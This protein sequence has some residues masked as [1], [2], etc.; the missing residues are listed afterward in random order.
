MKKSLFLL[1]L[2][3]IFSSL[4][5]PVGGLICNS[6]GE[7]G[8]QTTPFI[9]EM[10]EVF[11]LIEEGKAIDALNRLSLIKVQKHNKALYELLYAKA[12]IKLGRLT[13][14]MGHLQLSI[15]YGEGRIK[16]EALFERAR[17]YLSMKFYPEAATAFRLF[18]NLFPDSIFKEKAYH[19][20]AEAL[21][22]KGQY[23][24][25]LRYYEKT[26]STAGLYGKANTL[27]LMG[28]YEEAN[29][30]YVE[31]IL[32]DPGFIKTSTETALL[33]GENM[34]L[35]KKKAE[36]RR[37]L[38]A[39]KDIPYRYRAYLLL[40][41]MEM[42]DGHFNE[43]LKYLDLSLQSEEITIRQKAY[44]MSAEVLL[45]LGKEEEAKKRLLELRG[46]YPFGEAYERSLLLLSMIYKKE[47][48]FTEASRVLRSLIFRRRLSPDAV[49]LLKEILLE[50]SKKEFNTFL[51]LWKEHKKL[52][53]E[54]SNIPFLFEIADL[55]RQREANTE[56]SELS[57]LS[58]WLFKN[59]R[60]E[61][62]RKAS[63]L[64]AEAYLMSGEAEIGLRILQDIRPKDD[65]ELRLYAELFLMKGEHERA[66]K[67]LL[68]IKGFKKEDRRL[69]MKIA[70][71]R[72]DKPSIDLLERFI[73][74]YGADVS[75]YVSLAD[76]L[77]KNGRYAEA[78][79][80]YKK[81]LSDELKKELPER[82][83]EWATYRVSAIEDKNKTFSREVTVRSLK[84]LLKEEEAMLRRLERSL[85]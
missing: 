7:D 26:D 24:E 49:S 25:A 41:K 51:E 12:L 79:Y 14:A 37:Y 3:L 77:Y 60:G 54:D 10:N 36:A 46:H 5:V 6:W 55:L 15:S 84:A 32:R 70:L 30:L 61:Y 68:K 33:I 80:Y 67:Y 39:V 11:R 44:L 74:K 13:Q 82:E 83:L 17:L 34:S 35:L 20:L 28:R 27:H 59:T 66:L 65:K 38:G 64:M 9:T 78:L 58:E 29:R 53:L 56:Q 81:A 75:S 47:G 62:K 52:F 85:R 31:L 57:F 45:K 19:G 50:A 18:L 8:S 2:H 63:L 73:K 23:E 69:L 48:S 16:E 72:G 43:A 40:G 42:E 1:F 4:S 22:K 76:L 21:R 71:Q